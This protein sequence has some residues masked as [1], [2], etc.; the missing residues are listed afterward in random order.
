[1]T[2]NTS[3]RKAA[4]LA[5]PLAALL[6]VG[7]GGR[8]FSMA[9]AAFAGGIAGGLALF[10]Y[11]IHLLSENMRKVAGNRMRAF[12]Q[13]TTKNRW[14]GLLAGVVITVLMQSSSA[15][16]VLLVSFSQAHLVNAVQSVGVILGSNIGTTVTTQIIAF[17]ITNYAL[18]ILA[19]GYFSALASKTRQG[20]W[21]GF[22]VAGMGF[23]FYGMHLMSSSMKPLGEE[24]WF[25]ELLLH[26]QNPL[27]GIL[28]AAALTAVIQSSAAF[29]GIVI[30]L[31]QQGL[32]T[33]DSG[34]P[35]ILGANIGTCVTALLASL[36][37]SREARRVALIHILFN[38]LGVVVFLP[39]LDHLAWLVRHLSPEA[40]TAANALPRQIANAHTL[41]NLIACLLF[42]P[43][44]NRLAAL[45][46]VLMPVTTEEFK[47]MALPK[48]LDW[49]LINTPALAL[50]RVRLELIYIG[51]IVG[52]MINDTKD[53]LLH[54]DEA[55][56]A[57]VIKADDKVDRLIEQT[58][59]Y[60]ARILQTP[61]SD[62]QVDEGRVLYD[63]LAEVDHLA[64]LLETSTS[65]IILR[66]I[67]RKTWMSDQ[68]I[69]EVGNLLEGVAQ[70]Y[71][72]AMRFVAE[73]RLDILPELNR[74]KES[75][76][77]IEEASRRVH[78]ERVAAGV[79][80]AVETHQLHLDLLDQV[81]IMQVYIN[82]IIRHEE[83]FLRKYHME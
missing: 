46:N 24:P 69:Q 57:R 32:M 27:L 59:A 74:S 52:S 47:E 14:S 39:F 38:V 55:R 66:K 61:L 6:F 15:T 7:A 60:L 80:E 41:F 29:T 67:E 20:R 2:R 62:T 10:L 83:N 77:N 81:H 3:T 25:G 58:N 49:T 8:S 1:M 71:A 48:Y 79:P 4:A 78:Y 13:A 33:L 75:L 31:A 82:E 5:M 37:A 28:A 45:V 22:A 26:L 73:P 19:G 42:L 72:G 51:E 54:S 68:G 23:I 40:A 30:A 18:L 43:F 9:S 64:D 65:R 17:K 70:A 50:E 44:T 36:S 35:L 34:I 12:F 76:R 11:G 63:I 16:T 21:I 56:I 53:G